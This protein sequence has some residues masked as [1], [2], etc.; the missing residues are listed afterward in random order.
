VQVPA[1]YFEVLD[2]LINAAIAGDVIM[3]GVHERHVLSEISRT[4]R[5]ASG[6]VAEPGTIFDVYR[7]SRMHGDEWL[8][9][10]SATSEERARQRVREVIEEQDELL[11]YGPDD[12]R[13]E[14]SD[15]QDE[16]ELNPND[17]YA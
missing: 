15:E 8:G 10:I 17:E 14:Q 6:D 5:E 2:E 7:E 9:W 3:L 1:V 11:S 4:L 13:V 12:V 16:S